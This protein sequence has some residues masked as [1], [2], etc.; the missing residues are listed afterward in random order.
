VMSLPMAQFVWIVEFSTRAQWAS[1]HV[2]VR[3]VLDA[4]ASVYDNFPMWTIFDS[5]TAWFVDRNNSEF[6][7]GD[8]DL[9]PTNVPYSRMS[10]NLMNF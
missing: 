2:Q 6:V 5:K 1:G 7:T 3:A 4:T 8:Q 9:V 10:T